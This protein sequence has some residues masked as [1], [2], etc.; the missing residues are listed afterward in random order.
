[1]D[2]VT[3]ALFG[4]VMYN[5]IDREKLS[6]EEK[7]SLLFVSVVGSEIPDI[8]VISQL[9][10]R[11]GEYLMWH[12]GITHSIFLVPLWAALLTALAYLKWRVSNRRLFGVALLAVF[13]HITIDIFNP[14]GTGYW[15]PFSQV[16]LAL[17]TIP[18]I[19]LVMWAIILGGFIAARFGKWPSHT[20]FRAVAC[21]LLLQVASQ[22]TQGLMV[23]QTLSPQYDQVTL[24]ADFVPGS[25]KVIGKRGSEVEITQASLWSEP[26]LLKRISSAE[27]TD[28]APLFAQKPEALTL[29]QWAPMV[30]IVNNEQRLGI[31]DPRFYQRGESFLYEYVEK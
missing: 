4:L 8:D 6:R 26:I 28:L 7:R 24:A 31:F 17:G 16:R 22:T 14:W 19:D 25:Y 23:Q 5:A 15:E 2:T 30:V 21:L 13:I 3:H 12:R 10:D 11:G 29:Y 18:I 9:W 27:G 1:M 20:V